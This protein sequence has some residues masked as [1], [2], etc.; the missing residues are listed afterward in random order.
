MSRRDRRLQSE[1]SVRSAMFI[2]RT[3]PDAPP[4]SVGAAQM[5]GTGLYAR[6][7]RSHAAPTEL[8]G[9]CGTRGYKHGAPNG[10]LPVWAAGNTG[11]AQR[12][13]RHLRREAFQKTKNPKQALRVCKG[14]FRRLRKLMVRANGAQA[15]HGRGRYLAE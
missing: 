8:G 6:R 7:A 4:S 12:G 13:P 3:S 11:K 1:S 15:A 2:V 9:P 10:A 14:M 5:A